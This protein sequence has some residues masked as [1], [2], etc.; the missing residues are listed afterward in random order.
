MFII[1]RCFP[2]PSLSFSWTHVSY[3]LSGTFAP[4]H[5]SIFY[6]AIVLLFAAV[7][8]NKPTVFY[9]Y[10]SFSTW[11]VDSGGDSMASGSQMPGGDLLDKGEK[12]LKLVLKVGPQDS[13]DNFGSQPT[14][15]RSKHKHKKKK[16][17]KEGKEKERDEVVSVCVCV[18]VCSFDIF[19]VGKE[20]EENY[21][22]RQDLSCPFF[23]LYYL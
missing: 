10:F 8:K 23:I 16:K 4:T 20:Q 3:C 11:S 6:A 2:N 22:Y 9:F 13:T 21:I 15:E 12:P 14:E 7:V 19:Y 17:K 5:Y 1:S 18:F